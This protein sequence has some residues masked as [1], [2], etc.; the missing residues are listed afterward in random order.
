MATFCPPVRACR[1]RIATAISGVHQARGF[2]ATVQRHEQIPFHVNGQGT[3]VAQSVQVKNSEHK[4]EADAFPTFGGKDAA[5]SP[6]HYNLTSL[7][8]CTQVTGS[9]VAKDLGISLKK[10]NVSVGGKLNPAVLVQGVE[11]SES[12]LSSIISSPMMPPHVQW[13]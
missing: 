3:G 2:S 7:S 11:G 8:T 12:T 1:Q 13:H 6:L 9:L 10:W 5:P 4:I